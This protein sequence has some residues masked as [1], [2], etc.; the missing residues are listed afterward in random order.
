M[1][2]TCSSLQQRVVGRGRLL[3]EDVEGGAR[4][5]A[6][7]DRAGQ[8]QLVDEPAAG[9]VDEARA[10]LEAR[11]LRLAE[12][13][14]RVAGE[15]RVDRDEVGA[16][17]ELVE[18]DRLHAQA[19]GG[20]AC[21]VGVVGDH[22][23]A[24][25]DGPP[26]DLGPDPAEAEDAQHLAEQLDALQAAFLPAPRL[27]REVGGGES[28]GHRE[29]EPH[30]VLG[31]R[32]GVPARCVHDDH[33]PLGRGVHVDR[34]DAGAGPADDLQARAGRDHRAG[35]LGGAADDETLVLADA[36]GQ[37][38]LAQRAHHLDVEA[39]LAERVDADRLQAVGDE[40]PLHDFS[41]KIFCAARTLA[42][43]STG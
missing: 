9:A 13:V 36:R 15:R 27:Q 17:Q 30:R 28:A 40:D 37:V 32:G 19:L 34:V 38:A 39:V 21:Q 8:R 3:L 24:E 10:R 31:D 14:A 7:L 26:R 12:Q 11:Q 16:R 42:P 29:Q 18:L 25:A 43:K 41:A 4:D 20:L 33:A 1:T 2:T 6:R 35:H 22:V 23:H 5:A